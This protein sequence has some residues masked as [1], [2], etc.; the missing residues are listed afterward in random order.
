[1]KDVNKELER[2]L[3]KPIDLGIKSTYNPKTKKY[4]AFS[5]SFTSDP[6][7]YRQDLFSQVGLPNGPRSWDEARSAAAKIKK[8]LGNP[9][10][11]GLANAI[12]TGMPMRAN[13][14]SL[15]TREQED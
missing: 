11:V 8:Q 15:R 3:G 13:R 12:D 2:K 4:Y 10:G 1:M 9:F 5:P 6:V 14:D 7:N